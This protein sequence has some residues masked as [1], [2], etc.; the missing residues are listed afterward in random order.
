MKRS[1]TIAAVA[2]AVS[3][4]PLAGAD[5]GAQK[6]PVVEEIEGVSMTEY[7][8]NGGSPVGDVALERN[9][10][11]SEEEENALYRT[12]N[13]GEKYISNVSLLFVDEE[14][15][16]GLYTY[17]GEQVRTLNGYFSCIGLERFEEP[18]YFGCRSIKT[19]YRYLEMFQPNHPSPDRAPWSEMNQ[20]LYLNLYV[21]GGG[22]AYRDETGYMELRYKARWTLCKEL[23]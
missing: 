16:G 21:L 19:L 13:H 18:E 23:W 10:R 7:F 2:V 5:L 12:N 4:L 15:R 9:C 14:D 20:E 22:I 3:L 11:P 17:S 6:Y 8:V 1:A